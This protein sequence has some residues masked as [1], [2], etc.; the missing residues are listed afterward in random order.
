MAKEL[1]YFDNGRFQDWQKS[2][3]A[4]VG[5]ANSLIDK[6]H[7]V[8]K[9]HKVTTRD[10]FISLVD[11]P[12]GRLD[13][14]LQKNVNMSAFGGMTPDLDKLSEFISIDRKAWQVYCKD[15]R[16]IT[17]DVFLRIEKYTDFEHGRFKLNPQA[18]EKKK[19]SYSVFAETPKEEDNL[20]HLQNLVA[21][22]NKHL[23][24][25]YISTTNMQVVADALELYYADNTVFL[26][27]FKTAQLIKLQ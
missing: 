16:S 9:W 24:K 18:L 1:V 27:E 17:L 6:W 2:V 15:F 10:E 21:I 5:K 20:K 22:L 19:E 25:G 12:A 3:S 13:E 8:Q 11:N 26:N 14:E 4:T 7:K 23:K